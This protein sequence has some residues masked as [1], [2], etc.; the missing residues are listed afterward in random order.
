M[1]IGEYTHS[2]DAKKRLSLPAKFRKELGKKVVITHGLDKCL[3][4]YT[5]K[6]WDAVSEKLSSLSMGQYDSRGFTRFILAG[7]TEIDIDSIGRV[8][9]PDYLKEFANLSSKV[10]LTGVFNRVEI[11]N[12]KAWQEY[13]KNIEQNADSLAEKL[14]E[15]GVI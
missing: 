6:H 7:A 12:E 8:L 5:L 3:F 1:L 13:K 14:G 11:W 9:I 15:I 4:V 2:L 10:I